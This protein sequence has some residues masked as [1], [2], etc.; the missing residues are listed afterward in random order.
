MDSTD[1]QV[2]E[3]TRRLLGALYREEFRSAAYRAYHRRARE[4]KLRKML[5][6]FLQAQERMIGLLEGHLRDLGVQRAGRGPLRSLIGVA[7]SAAGRLTSLR[8]ADA[9]LRRVQSEE[10]RGAEYYGDEIDWEG[11]STEEKQTLEGHACDQL[12][13]KKWAGTVE[14]DLNA[15]DD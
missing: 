15:D 8:G 5:G 11:W 7:G 1:T 3:R 14:R 6:T 9:I 2:R 10:T 4:E 12:Y 13:Q